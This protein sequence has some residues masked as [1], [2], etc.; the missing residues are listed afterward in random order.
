MAEV[1]PPLSHSPIHSAPPPLCSH[2]FMWGHHGPDLIA[3]LWKSPDPWSG[4]G[5]P[6]LNLSSLRTPHVR[7]ASV[8]TCS[9]CSGAT[10]GAESRDNDTV[11]A[12]LAQGLKYQ[13]RVIR[14]FTRIISSR[15]WA[16]LSRASISDSSRVGTRS[17]TSGSGSQCWVYP[18]LSAI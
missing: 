15:L 11:L 6:Q 8:K 13:L 18:L 17:L 1:T 3:N 7:G 10:T 4:G 5:W 12:S 2:S 9:G 14:F 16:A